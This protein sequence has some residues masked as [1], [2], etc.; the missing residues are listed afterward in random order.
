MPLFGLYLWDLSLGCEAWW[1]SVTPTAPRRPGDWMSDLG[2][3]QGSSTPVRTPSLPSQDARGASPSLQVPGP[4]WF[5]E[6]AGGSRFLTGMR[7]LVKG[8]QGLWFP[9]A[10]LFVHLIVGRDSI[11]WHFPEDHVSRTFVEI[12][13]LTQFIAICLGVRPGG[14]L[15]AQ[16][17]FRE[18]LSSWGLAEWTGP[19]GPCLPLSQWI[20][21]AV[22]L[23]AMSSL[24]VGWPENNQRLMWTGTKCPPKPVRSPLWG[25]WSRD[26]KEVV[27]WCWARVPKGL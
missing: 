6:P 19:V 22:D 18:C 4:G 27:G 23:G 3:P 21:P 10:M 16:L 25:I 1:L 13:S 17:P 2:K 24:T 20:V 9:G 14:S 5:E 12:K 11:S 26:Q 15:L 7:G 8:T